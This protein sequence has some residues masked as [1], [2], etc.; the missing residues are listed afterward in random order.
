M[1]AFEVIGAQSTAIGATLAAMTAITGDSFA[2]KAFD[3]GKKAYLLQAWAAPQ[4]AG[5]LRIRS[6]KFHDNVNGIRYRT[7][8]GDFKPVMPWGAKETLFP[9]DVLTVELAGS[10]V[11]GQIEY[12]GMLV[13]Y[14]DLPGSAARLL[15]RD[16]L[17]AR[18]DH[19]ITV[20]NT[21]ATPTTGGYAGAQAINTTIDQF[22]AGADYA[23]L[24]YKCSA[25]M[26]I[27]GYK[28]P[29]FGNL[30]VAGPGDASDFDLYADWF[31]RLSMFNGLPMIP[32]FNGQNKASLNI[33]G[34]QDQAGA[35][36]VIT[37]W[38]AK[39]KAA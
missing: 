27:L 18:I 22:Q 32:V 16:Q 1:P 35:D 21:I 38:L 23:I 30:R 8:S 17:L 36:P 25:A 7:T 34:A 11:A 10:A 3:L 24:G 33:D 28:C 15:T 4:A 5:T 26:G 6:P 2:I 13:Y 31:M 39:L 29:E 14:E 19:I 20:E 37:T 12:A 9:T